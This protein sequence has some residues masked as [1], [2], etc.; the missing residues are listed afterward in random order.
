[1]ILVGSLKQATM[2]CLQLQPEVVGSKGST[3]HK[4]GQIDDDRPC[5]DVHVNDEYKLI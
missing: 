1:M 4:L 5:D 2:L 3:V